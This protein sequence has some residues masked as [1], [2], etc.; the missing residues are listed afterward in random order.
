MTAIAI[1]PGLLLAALHAVE[2]DASL[3]GSVGMLVAVFVIVQI[4][5]D[6]LVTP[7]VMGKATG[8]RPVTI[9]LGLFIWGKLLGFLGLIL[10]IP[11]TCLA[12][13]YY[14]KYVLGQSDAAADRAG[15]SSG[16][17]E[18]RRSAN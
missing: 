6:T 9:L 4:I 17:G 16:K 10:A 7:R 3:L 18:T 11:L 1:V 13:A 14:R 8:L 12:I 5:Q 2:S 15:E